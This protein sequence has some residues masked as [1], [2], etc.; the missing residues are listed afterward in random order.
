[1]EAALSATSLPLHGPVSAAESDVD[2]DFAPQ[3]NRAAFEAQL[4]SKDKALAAHAQ[5]MI[6]RIDR[7]GKLPEHYA[8]PVQV[9]R[10][11]QELTI[12][13][14]G[15]E[16]VV[17]YSLRLKKELRGSAIWVAGYSNDV[18]AYIPSKRVLEEGGYEGGDSMKWGNLPFPWA[19]TTEE[20]IM[21]KVHGL[22]GR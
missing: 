16:T 6:N 13:A 4:A 15:G 17:D 5:R 19:A 12:V 11:G 3:G 18:M 10:F 21:A 9:I 7:E 8:Y 2:L 14:L 1:V 22:V 20:R